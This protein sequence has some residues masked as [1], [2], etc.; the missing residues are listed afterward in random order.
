MIKDKKIS[1]KNLSS[2]NNTVFNP[3]VAIDDSIYQLK[4]HDQIDENGVYIFDCMYDKYVAPISK[5]DFVCAI[6]SDDKISFVGELNQQ[7]V[8]PNNGGYLFDFLLQEQY[9]LVQQKQLNNH[10]Y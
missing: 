8:I 7:L 4:D 5:N 1:F 2:A 6:V 9:I 10:H 3:S